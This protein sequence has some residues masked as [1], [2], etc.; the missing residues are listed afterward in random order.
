[1]QAIRFGG[2]TDRQ[3]FAAR[4]GR[5]IHSFNL[6]KWISPMRLKLTESLRGRVNRISVF[7]CPMFSV[8]ENCIRG[9]IY[10][11]VCMWRDVPYMH[12]TYG[13]ALRFSIQLYSSWLRL[14]RCEL[15]RCSSMDVQVFC[16]YRDFVHS[17]DSRATLRRLLPVVSSKIFLSAVSECFGRSIGSRIASHASVG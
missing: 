14:H 6:Q 10:A 12:D 11:Y 15:Q 7:C 2:R 9:H 8:S 3:R 5:M 17:V 1:M 13:D 4:F 16:V